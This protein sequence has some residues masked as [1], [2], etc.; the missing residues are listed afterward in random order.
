MFYYY[1]LEVIRDSFMISYNEEY[2]EE[3][4]ILDLSPGDE[5]AVIPPISGG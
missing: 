4:A 3:N 5:I 1:S 2:I